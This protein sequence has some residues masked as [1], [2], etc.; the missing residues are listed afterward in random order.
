MVS[1]SVRTLVSRSVQACMAATLLLSS[2]QRPQATHTYQT[3][4]DEGW[5]GLEPLSFT[6]DSLRTGGFYDLRLGIRI[7][8]SYPY[9][10]MWVIVEQAWEN[11]A[12]R[13]I[14]TLRC[15]LADERGGFSGSGIGTH[16]YEFPVSRTRLRPLQ[17]GTIQVRHLMR[18][19]ML[20]G[21]ADIGIRFLP[22]PPPSH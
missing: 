21:V 17:C 10:S 13:R 8:H 11:P 14:D 15:F 2:C 16:Q 5:S 4:S 20:P 19:E 3:I 6:I 9:R 1:H 12:Y 7:T 22:V 18:H